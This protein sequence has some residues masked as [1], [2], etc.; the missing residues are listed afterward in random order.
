[1]LNYWD[2]ICD[3]VRAMFGPFW[4]TFWPSFTFRPARALKFSRMGQYCQRNMSME[5][6]L[7]GHIT[8]ML[9]PCLA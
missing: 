9:G 2:H 6:L 7:L 1:M 8:V 5:C 3:H 4:D